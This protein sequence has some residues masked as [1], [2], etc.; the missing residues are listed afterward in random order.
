MTFGVDSSLRRKNPS[1][2]G[3]GCVATDTDDTAIATWPVLVSPNCS[4]T[5]RGL[6]SAVIVMVL[7]SAVEWNTRRRRRTMTPVMKP[8]M[9]IFDTLETIQVNECF[10]VL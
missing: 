4:K 8:V 3:F 6:V 5:I 9:V 2:D 1:L 7:I 10:S